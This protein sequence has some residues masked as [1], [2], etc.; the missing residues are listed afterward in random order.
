ML[1]ER[2]PAHELRQKHETVVGDEPALQVIYEPTAQC[3]P[4]HPLEEPDDFIILKMVRHK[5]ADNNINRRG[6]LVF[7]HIAT[8]PLDSR[9]GVGERTG[10]RNRGCISIDAGQVNGEMSFVRPGF[11]AAQHIACAATNVDNVQC[12]TGSIDKLLEPLQGRPIG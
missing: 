7:V 10:C 5:R 4:F 9:F 6:R 3:G 12:R 8:V 1:N 2:V 11:D